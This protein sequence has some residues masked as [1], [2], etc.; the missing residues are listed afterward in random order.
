VIYRATTRA[1]REVE[2]RLA[3]SAADATVDDAWRRLSALHPGVDPF[4]LEIECRAIAPGAVARTASNGVVTRL[5]ARRTR[6][7]P[8]D[9]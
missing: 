9:V 3:M 7:E 6:A 5:D 8:A 4:S 1:G 2:L